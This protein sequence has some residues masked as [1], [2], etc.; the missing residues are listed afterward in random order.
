MRVISQN[1]I[2]DFPYNQI[3]VYRN[4]NNIMCRFSNV[5]KSANILGIYSTEEKAEMA[6]EMMRSVY[7]N[8]DYI[9]MVGNA[10]NLNTLY[11]IIGY[12]EFKKTASTYFK[13]PRDEEVEV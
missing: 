6:M 11:E 9:R 12:E 13:F 10:E 3:A 5:E 8:F 1:G 2:F 4:E 7:R